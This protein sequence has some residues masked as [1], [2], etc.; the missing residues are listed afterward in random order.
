MSSI[1]YLAMDS[2]ILEFFRIN[3]AEE[4]RETV[5]KFL[6]ENLGIDYVYFYLKFNESSLFNHYCSHDDLS[7]AMLEKIED[8]LSDKLNSESY[9]DFA[10]TQIITKD[11][12]LKLKEFSVLREE[13]KNTKAAISLLQKDNQD[14]YWQ[15][16]TTDELLELKKFIKSL[17]DHYYLLCLLDDLKANNS[18]LIQL[19]ENKTQILGTVSHELKTPM[20][21]ILG[22]SEL[23][24]NRDF[25]DRDKENYLSEIYSASKKLSHL[26]DDFLDLSRLESDDEVFLSDFEIVEVNELIKEAVDDI[27][28]FSKQHNIELD[29]AEDMPIVLCDRVAISRVL[30]NL[31]S[32]AIKYSPVKDDF[33]DRS[34]IICKTE[35][36]EAKNHQGFDQ[37]LISVTD[38]GIGIDPKHIK[39]IFDRFMRV[40]NSDIREIGG[41]GLGLWICN[42][43]VES[44]GGQIWC[45][46]KV[47]EGSSFKFSIPIFRN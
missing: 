5:S 15:K 42:K 14:S 26:I 16:I 18:R 39:N 27:K 30:H 23:L 45:E 10:S 28:S 21:A 36:E 3:E 4:F 37:I 47:K 24:V 34:T 33:P 2:K 35:L 41:T 46:S 40:D 20:S 13:N 17:L 44:H 19:N 9:Q 22:F 38:N 29:L 32:N 8:S 43:I 12:T 6:F 11:E 25:S 31:F 1:D 7:A